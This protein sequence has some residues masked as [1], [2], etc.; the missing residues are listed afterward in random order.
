MEEHPVSRQAA[1]T[2]SLNRQQELRTTPPPDFLIL[3]I[4]RS[5]DAKQLRLVN[6]FYKEYRNF[7]AGEQ[8]GVREVKE[9]MVRLRRLGPFQ[10]A[11]FQLVH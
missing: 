2:D 3:S 8:I 11:L 4:R 9:G 7:L 10:Q 1:R 5:I 6:I